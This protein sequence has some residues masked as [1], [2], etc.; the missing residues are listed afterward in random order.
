MAN[1]VKDPRYD[2]TGELPET[3]DELFS[4][5][6]EMDDMAPQDAELYRRYKMMSYR[7]KHE[8]KVIDEQM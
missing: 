1:K 3:E 6:F 4:T 2:I 7:T 5:D 8:E